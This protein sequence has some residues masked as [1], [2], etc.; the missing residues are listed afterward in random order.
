MNEITCEICMD[1]MPLVHD[2]VASSDSTAAVRTHIR[3]CPQCAALFEGQ[4]PAPSNRERALKKLQKQ[5]RIFS[6]MVLMFGIFYGLMLTAGSGLFYNII[7]MPVIGAIGYYL[8]QWSALYKIPVLLLITHIITNTL[9]LGEEYLEPVS[10]LF[11]T[12][13]YCLFALLGSVIAALLHFALK[14]EESK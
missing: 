11:W 4:Y 1:L 12:G 5:S 14:K 10:L 7:I 8:F 9:G 6:A 2:G 3:N 13:L